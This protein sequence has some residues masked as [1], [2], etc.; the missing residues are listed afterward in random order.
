MDFQRYVA[1]QTQAT[2]DLFNCNGVAVQ[3]E[4]T[5]DTLQTM[6]E[7]FCRYYN[8]LVDNYS[9][10]KPQFRRILNQT[11]VPPE[12]P[13]KEKFLNDPTMNGLAEESGSK[14]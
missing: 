1:N 5:D 9:A 2:S 13:T 12:P 11:T 14:E 8:F 6:I 4:S 3:N 7:S 10:E